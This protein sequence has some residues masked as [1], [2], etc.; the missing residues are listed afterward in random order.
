MTEKFVRFY[1]AAM[2]ALLMGIFSGCSSMDD[3]FISESDLSVEALEAKMAEKVDPT[4]AYRNSKGFIFRQTIKVP[5]FLDDDIETMVETKMVLPDK[6]RITTLQDNEP[7]QIICSNGNTGWMSESSGRKLKILEGE[8]L[9][10]LLTLS[11]LGTPAGG[12]R[13]IFNKVEISRCSNDDGDFY[14][15]DCTGRNGNSFRFYID[16]EEFLL[17]RM[18]G[19][20]NVGNGVLEYDSRVKSYGLFSGVMIPKVTETLQNGQKQIVELLKYE[21][22]PEI[23]ETDFLPPVFDK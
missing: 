16:D 14:V 11:K 7:I 5:Q 8:K 4:G 1:M 15:L 17:R 9:Q 2:F 23:P 22:N 18:K 20:M 13:K 19:R 12:Y 10:Q 3:D 21:L 6:F